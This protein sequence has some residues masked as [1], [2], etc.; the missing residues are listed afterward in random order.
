MSIVYDYAGVAAHLKG[1]DWWEAEKPAA[2]PEQMDPVLVDLMKQVANPSDP[3]LYGKSPAMT[4]IEIVNKALETATFRTSLPAEAW[5][6]INVLKICQTTIPPVP[7]PQAAIL[8]EV[9]ETMES[10]QK[11]VQDIFAGINFRDRSIPGL[12]NA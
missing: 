4:A 6:N 10:T 3:E 9:R 12:P 8:A 7:S 1:D 2:E 5:R 11:M